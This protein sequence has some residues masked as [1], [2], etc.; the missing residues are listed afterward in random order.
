MALVL[1]VVSLAGTSTRHEG[2]Y[3]LGRAGRGG[4][5]IH[6]DRRVTREELVEFL[7][8]QAQVAHDAGLDSHQEARHIA[9]NL[10][11]VMEI[12]WKRLTDAG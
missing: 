2:A 4:R 7:Q 9:G 1:V 10:L 3:L 5:I 6:K 8:R 12:S 11:A